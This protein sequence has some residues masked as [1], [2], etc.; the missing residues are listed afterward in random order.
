VQLEGKRVT[1]AVLGIGLNVNLAR[2]E[3]PAELATIATSLRI[4]SGARLD[5]VAVAEELLLRLEPELDRV[6][7]GDVESLLDAW[8]KYFRMRG[9]RVRIGGPG[10]ARELEG[11]V[12]GIDADGALLLDCNGTRERVLAGDVSLL[13]REAQPGCC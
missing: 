1:S 10:I 7:S 12:E 9:S 4:A 6:R 11:V 13:Q 5:R 8:R 2:E 3:L